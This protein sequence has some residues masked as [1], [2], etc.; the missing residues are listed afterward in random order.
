MWAR[1]ADNFAKD[2]KFEDAVIS[3]NRAGGIFLI[4]LIQ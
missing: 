3:H 1:K 2:G 4:T